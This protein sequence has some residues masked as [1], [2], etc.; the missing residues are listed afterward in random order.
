[1]LLS[2]NSSLDNEDVR[3]ILQSTA[4]DLGVPGRDETYGHGLLNALAAVKEAVGWNVTSCNET[5]SEKNFFAPG[6]KV[7]VKG[8]LAPSTTY[9]A[10]IQD[11]PV[12]DGDEL[13]TTED[14][15]E[16]Q[17]IIITDNKGDFGPLEIWNISSQATATN[18][19]YDIVMDKQD[20][21]SDTGKYTSELDGFDSASTAGIIAPVPEMATIT[22]VLIGIVITVFGC[23]GNRQ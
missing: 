1:M 2:V 13:N 22:L 4:D 9:K 14:P 15:S 23:G 19:E 7:Y 8:R 11:D 6:D 18:K 3:N 5:G 12:N 21:G 10:W 20:D 16:L 17:E